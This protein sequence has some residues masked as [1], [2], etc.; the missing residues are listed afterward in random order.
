[1]NRSQRRAS[2]SNGR[3]LMKKGWNDFEQLS[4][5]EFSLATDIRIKNLDRIYINNIFVVQVFKPVQTTW[6]EL[7]KV[8][9]RRNDEAPVHSW[10]DLQRIKNEVFGQNYYAIEVYPSE[11]DVVDVANMYW[12]WVLSNQQKVPFGFDGRPND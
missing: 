6:G 1:M 3:N 7:I 4:E 5:I 11:M 8:G 12:I 9:V 2:I 10:S